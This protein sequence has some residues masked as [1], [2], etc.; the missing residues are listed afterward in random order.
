MTH[1]NG[2][3][4]LLVDDDPLVLAAT[5]RFLRKR[6]IRTICASSPFGVTALVRKEAPDAVVLDCHM[7]GLDGA[8][9]LRVLRT[10]PGTARTPV[11][12]YS[13]EA[14]HTL[15][16]LAQSL[17]VRY[18]A[19]GRGPVPLVEMIF[20]AL[21][22]PLWKASRAMSLNPAEHLPSPTH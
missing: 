18:A 12:F 8:F 6:G 1:E 19:K 17:G 2:I 13:G 5:S 10:S 20:A 15:A 7:P 3:S 11:I 14:E 21:K 4:V 16:E 9:L 22:I